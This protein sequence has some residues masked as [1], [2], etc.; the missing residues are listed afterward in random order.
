M[1]QIRLTGGKILPIHDHYSG[2]KGFVQVALGFSS[3]K[4]VVPSLQLGE[5]GPYLEG[6]TWFPSHL[7]L[8]ANYAVSDSLGP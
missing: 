1:S 5:V 3:F 8:E 7:L 6:G 4:L 2:I